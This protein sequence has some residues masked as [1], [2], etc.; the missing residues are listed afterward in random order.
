CSGS[1]FTGGPDRDPPITFPYSIPPRP[2]PRDAPLRPP[3]FRAPLS[4][5]MTRLLA[6]LSPLGALL[7]TAPLPLL[8]PPAVQTPADDLVP[9]AGQ[10]PHA[11][12]AD[13]H[14]R[15]LLQ[16]VPLAPDVGRDLVP[17]GEP[18]AGDLPQRRVGLLG[19]RRPDDQAHPALLRAGLEVLG[20]GLGD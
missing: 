7:G 3:P 9:H 14:D 12:A 5:P 15:V 6:S 17:V 11:P 16:V 1:L 13:Q 18:H 8:P 10:V 20:L 4:K 2:P 19:G